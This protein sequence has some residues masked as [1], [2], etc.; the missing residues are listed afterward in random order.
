MEP[1]LLSYL[2]LLIGAAGT[3]VTLLASPDILKIGARLRAAED[4]RTIL[5]LVPFVR[6]F[7]TLLVLATFLFLLGLGLA[8]V[9][10][11]VAKSY[12]ANNPMLTSSLM[13]AGLFSGAAAATLA[14]AR[15]SFF[16]PACVASFSAAVLAIISALDDT[17][18]GFSL[19]LAISCVVFAVSGVAGILHHIRAH[20]P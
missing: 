17:L 19:A 14:V 1:T 2:N 11:V 16:F 4:D 9:L 10:Q 12:G 6:V 7:A 3:A 5:D 15:S 13:I 18:S 8:G 20:L